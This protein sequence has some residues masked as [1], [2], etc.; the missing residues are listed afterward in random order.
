[1]YLINSMLQGF[2]WMPR[3]A[4]KI[5]FFSHLWWITWLLIFVV[6]FFPIF[7]RFIRDWW[8][9]TRVQVH[10]FFSLVLLLLL[11]S[12]LNLSSVTD[13]V[14]KISPYQ[15]CNNFVHWLDFL[16]VFTWSVSCRWRCQNHWKLL[17]SLLG[18]S[19][20]ILW[21]WDWF[22]FLSYRSGFCW[23]LGN[24]VNVLRKGP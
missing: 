20:K 10:S 15:I 14:R 24:V 11:L 23:V 8:Y 17:E 12:G 2:H 18:S 6:Y 19:C 7:L 9:G 4:R 3:E 16:D 21:N 5:F 1:M 22:P 13:R